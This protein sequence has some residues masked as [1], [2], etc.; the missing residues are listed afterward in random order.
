MEK[1]LLVKTMAAV[2]ENSSNGTLIVDFFGEIIYCNPALNQILG[3]KNEDIRGKNFFQEIP[4]IVKPFDE[5]LRLDEDYLKNLF[6]HLNKSENETRVVLGER[7]IFACYHLHR[8]DFGEDTYVFIGVK[9]NSLERLS[10]EARIMSEKIMNHDIRAQ[11]NIINGFSQLIE[12]EEA[13]VDG[14]D[15]AKKFAAIINKAGNNILAIIENQS[16]I[17][18]IEM[19]QYQPER[20]KTNMLEFFKKEVLFSV[21][22][23]DMEAKITYPGDPLYLTGVNIDQKIIKYLLI[24]LVKNSFEACQAAGQKNIFISMMADESILTITIKNPGAIPKE[25]RDRFMSEG[26]TFGKKDGIGLGV[27]SA[28]LIA[29][30]NGGRISWETSDEENTT[31]ISVTLPL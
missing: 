16:L 21:R 3:L 20:K 11:L 2:H 4:K 14:S 22:H 17:R 15:G 7:K 10:D 13:D 26:A 9:D 24:N 28:K 6:K 1:E 8:F 23:Q 27:F 5:K 29:E 18:K 30:A 12:E 19:G 25:I 31:T